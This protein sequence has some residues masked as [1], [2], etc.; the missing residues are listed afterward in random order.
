MRMHRQ[1]STRYVLV[2]KVNEIVAPVERTQHMAQAAGCSVC[3]V[4]AGQA[5]NDTKTGTRLNP[6]TVHHERFE[7]VL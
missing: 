4:K 7:A 3:G 5:C 6:L 2:D 1:S